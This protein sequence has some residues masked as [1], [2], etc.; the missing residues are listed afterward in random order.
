MAISTIYSYNDRNIF[1]IKTLLL[2]LRFLL[3]NVILAFIFIFLTLEEID[4]AFFSIQ[5]GSNDVIVD[6]TSWNLTKIF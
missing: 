2:G 5:S 3:V 4:W 1:D 6:N